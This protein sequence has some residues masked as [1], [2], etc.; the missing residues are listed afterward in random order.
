MPVPSRARPRFVL[1]ALA[2]CV[3]A[4]A[5]AGPTQWSGA[6]ALGSQL[7][8]RG[9]AVTPPTPTVQGALYWTPAPGWSLGLSGG[10]E[11]R[12][13]GRLVQAIAQASHYWPVSTNW[14]MQVDLLYY[15]RPHGEGA[16][17]PGR[18]EAGLGWT[19]RDVL[20]F[21]LSA[22][23][24]TGGQNRE[25]HGAADL[26]LHWPLSDHFS[27]SAGVGIAQSPAS[28]YGRYDYGHANHYSYGQAGLIWNRGP[29]NIEL[30]RVVTG[31]GASR[32]RGSPRVSPWVATIS[33]A[34]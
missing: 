13:P 3:V 15:G 30:D 12:S 23:R 28:F 2:A 1:V 24:A 10:A 29:W 17:H 16:R 7:V 32:L 8:D 26:D 9:M 33:L 27:L 6:V 21:S 25:W 34:F 11:V 4:P 22:F 18:I 14:Q 20:S 19:Y 31:M 5:H